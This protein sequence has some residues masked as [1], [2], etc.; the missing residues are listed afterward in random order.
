[1]TILFWHS[2]FLQPHLSTPILTITFIYL[3]SEEVCGVG[4]REL[5]I[6][7]I[8]KVDLCIVCDIVSC[9]RRI[10]SHTFG[11]S[12]IITLF[13]PFHIHIF[14][15]TFG[16]SFPSPMQPFFL[17]CHFSKVLF[18]STP[19]P[20]SPAPNTLSRLVSLFPS[21]NNLPSTVYV[22]LL[23]SPQPSFRTLNLLPP[24][25]HVIILPPHAPAHIFN[26]SFQCPLTLPVPLYSN[27]FHVPPKGLMYKLFPYIHIL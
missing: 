22:L 6:R 14:P 10:Y 2:I 9:S 8:K 19:L 18:F 16:S 1:M 24:L 4:I 15:E 17:L 26:V 27:T 5:P 3:A 11:F 12:Y 25:Y 20:R 13:I 21:I 23:H 7:I